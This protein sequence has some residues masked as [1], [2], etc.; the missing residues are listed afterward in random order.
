M[1]GHDK[2]EI[3]PRSMDFIR[4][5][6]KAKEPFFAWVNTSRGHV[7]DAASREEAVGKSGAGVYN[8]GIVEL[9]ECVG[10]LL[11]LLDELK[12]ADNTIVMFTTDNGYEWAS[13]GLDGGFTPFKG[14]KGTSWE[15][16]FRVPMMARFRPRRDQEPR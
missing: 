1:P 14:E 7:L 10:S 11:D 4:E 9:D 12:I 16:G 6:A 2:D 5:A 8:D 13:P 15:G 3:L